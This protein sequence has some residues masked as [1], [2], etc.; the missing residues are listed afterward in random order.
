MCFKEEKAKAHKKEKRK[1]RKRKADEVED[2]DPDMAALMGFSG[3]GT[4]KKANWSGTSPCALF[5][6]VVVEKLSA[7]VHTH[8]LTTNRWTSVWNVFTLPVTP[9]TATR[10]QGRMLTSVYFCHHCV[11]VVQLTPERID[12]NLELQTCNYWILKAYG[13]IYT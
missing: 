12:T 5:V 9:T 3:F 6:V 11:Y 8:A 2:G 13:N 4:S 10:H 7:I 1:E